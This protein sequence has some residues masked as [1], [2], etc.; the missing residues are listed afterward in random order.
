MNILRAAAK[1]LSSKSGNSAV[2]FLA[3]SILF[4]GATAFIVDAGMMYLEK[5]KLQNGVD[6]IAL[7]AM[8]DFRK[9]DS[10]MM[11]QAYHYADLYNIAPSDLQISITSD[12]RSITV[13]GKKSVDFYFAKI[14]DMTGA[15][16]EA[17]AIAKAG[18]IVAADGIRPFAVE[19]QVFEHG[20]SYTLKKGAGDAYTGNYG[21]LALGGTGATTYKNNLMYGYNVDLKIG[22]LV[23]IGEDFDTEPG[24]MSGPTYEGV[25]YLI[26]KDTHEHIDLNNME[27]NCP[28][29]ITIPVIDSFDVQGRSTVK[30]MGFAK[31]YLDD[32][33]YTG[34]QTEIK[35]RFVRALEEGKI[36]DT[37]YDFGLFGVK[38]V[39]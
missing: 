38:L 11:S 30:I 25:K 3:M 32:V 14:F 27:P 22:D 36:G 35:G 18:A 17:K 39:E 31:F 2:I 23:S 37:E 10:S 19:Q 15:V 9:G 16:V 26:D 33:V 6:S 20:Q 12:K 13:T 28:R 34:G 1:H 5:T 21:A 7:A 24:N 8:Q 4:I 29:L